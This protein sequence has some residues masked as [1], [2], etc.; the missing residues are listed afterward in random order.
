MALEMRVYEEL[1]DID[2]KVIAGLTWRQLGAV[3]LMVVLGG[4]LVALMWFSGVRSGISWALLP[5]VVLI[6]AWA[7]FKPMGLRFEVWAGHVMA[8]KRRAQ[9]LRYSNEA[10]WQHQSATWGDIVK[11]QRSNAAQKDRKHEEIIQEAG[12]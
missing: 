12:Q 9:Q 5:V 7:W 10:I 11:G 1:S 3:G 4:G 6:A 2:P 8:Y